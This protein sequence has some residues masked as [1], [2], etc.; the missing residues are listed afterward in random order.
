MFIIHM[1]IIF[2]SSKD[3]RRGRKRELFIRGK[4]KRLVGHAVRIL[5]RA[6]PIPNSKSKTR[7]RTKEERRGNSGMQVNLNIVYT[8]PLG[9]SG[10]IV[11][12]GGSNR[13]RP[14]KSIIHREKE[15]HRK[16]LLL[17]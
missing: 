15:R 6:M 5:F 3:A 13:A 16:R 10:L 2:S 12:L 9:S 7:W 17:V 14:G 4:S 8:Q 11:H 1:T